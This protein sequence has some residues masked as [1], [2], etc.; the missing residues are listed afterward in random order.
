MT[1]S[2]VARTSQ[3]ACVLLLLV[4]SAI[5]RGD[6]RP[7]LGVEV[8]GCGE[9]GVEALLP[10]VALE[11]HART[12]PAAAAPPHATR[13]AV[14]CSAGA[15]ALQ[16]ADPL[17]TKVVTRSI[18]LQDV[19]P[20]ARARVLAIAIAELVSASWFELERARRDVRE[21]AVVSAPVRQER[22][23]AIRAV[24]ARSP[25]WQA[26]LG[27][28]PALWLSPSAPETGFGGSLQ[29]TADSP[30]PAALLLDLNGWFASARVGLGELH[31]SAFSLGAFGLLRA[32]LSPFAL[33]GGA[34]VRLGWAHVRGQSD[35]PTRAREGAVGGPWFG[36]AVAA[37]A[38][39]RISGWGALLLLPELGYAAHRGSRPHR[40][41]PRLGCRR[42]VG[43]ARPWRC[44]SAFDLS[45]SSIITIAGW[46]P[47]CT[48]IAATPSRSSAGRLPCSGS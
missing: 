4:P 43:H 29:F 48:S 47:T 23:A 7:L 28:G 33:Y 41:R 9:T 35:E 3:I 31:T 15:A 25:T 45:Q 34:G 11:L 46:S 14:R 19:H 22:A 44:T 18:A 26:S 13:V 21:A 20:S 1:P 17:T 38:A 5:A 37:G 36:P 24:R 30:G 6:E 12:L 2:H 39:L 10:I 40:R 16:V 8:D 32:E 27:L 42:A